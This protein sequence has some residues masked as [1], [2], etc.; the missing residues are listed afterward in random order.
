[1]NTD[2][3]S[4]DKPYILNLDDDPEFNNIL[5]VVPKKEGFKL[6]STKTP[7]EFAAKIKEKLESAMA[8]TDLSITS[9]CCCR[10][11]TGDVL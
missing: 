7:E 10:K 9:S 11:K 4:D 1:M 8:K 3:E 6:V 2:K 5:R